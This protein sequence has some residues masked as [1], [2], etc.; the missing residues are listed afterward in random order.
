[1]PR[2]Q[3]KSAAKLQRNEAGGLDNSVVVPPAITRI[4]FPWTSGASVRSFD[5]GPFY[6]CGCDEVVAYCQHAVQRRLATGQHR[7]ATI[8][9]ACQVALRRFF[10]F[11]A[12]TAMERAR[13]LTLK[14][15]DRAFIEGFVHWQR[16]RADSAQISQYGTF[17]AVKFVLSALCA[18]GLLPPRKE[19]FPVNP[20]PNASRSVNGQQPLSGTERERVCRALKQELLIV[21]NDRDGLN[22]PD[23]LVVLLIAI[24]L[25]TGRN[26]TP[27]LDLTRAAINAHPL[28][29]TW[30]VLRTM[31]YRAGGAERTPVSPDVIFL[32]RQALRLSEQYVSR[33]REPWR[34]KVWLFREGGRGRHKP[35]PV[36]LVTLATLKNAI[37]RFVERNDLRSDDD[38]VLKL[39]VS[40]LRKT[41]ANRLWRLS[42]GDPFAVGRLMG[43]SVRITDRHYLLPTPEMERNHKFVGEALVATW[44]GREKRATDDA[45]SI[46]AEETPVGRCRDPYTGALAPKDGRACMDFLSCFRC[47]SYVLVEEEADLWRLYSFYWFLVSERSRVGASRWAK[48][49]GWIV[50]LIDEQ[51]TARFDPVRVKAAR[52]Q[53]RVQPHPFW[54]DPN[55]KEAARAL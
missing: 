36:R 47:P 19:L 34:D 41:L 40:R 15:V 22:E 55:T 39:N 24:C 18:Q 43:H 51:V 20:Y 35:G 14:D 33:A 13:S 29:E 50:R 11:C 23:R 26:P 44:S 9:N 6:G 3:F 48:V 31:K 37:Q 32:Y 10:A 8:A 12:A 45:I 52:E 7:I 53:A 42:G 2:K 5:F 30:G 46:T 38:T 1:M 17:T 4:E 27:M 49:Y 16:Q 21:C 25:R 28:K 54:C